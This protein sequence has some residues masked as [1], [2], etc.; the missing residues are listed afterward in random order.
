MRK[1]RMLRRL[2]GLGFLWRS[3][4]EFLRLLFASAALCGLDQAVKHRID[5]EPEENFPRDMPG[6]KGKIRIVRAHNPG[7]SMGR[8]SDKPEFVKLSSLSITAFL[9]GALQLFCALCPGRFFV[10]KLGISLA[11]GGAASNVIDRIR[12]GRVTDYLNIRIGSFRRSIVNIGDLMI[13][14]GALLYG[15]S[16]LFSLFA[17][18]IR[19]AFGGRASLDGRKYDN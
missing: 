17:S 11:I 16:L 3:S 10:R 14:S 7:F 15:L 2:S 13:Q 8:M 18:L 1:K 4:P 9:L 5:G 6:T 12:R 19:H